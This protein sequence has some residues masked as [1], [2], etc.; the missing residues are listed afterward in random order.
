M[1]DILVRCPET[2]KPV[3]TGLDAE[4]VVLETL[5]GVALPVQCPHCGQ[6]H[7]WKPAE[8]WVWHGKSTRP[9]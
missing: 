4:T 5:P 3:Q 7:F 6:T 9:H 8:A 1:P 2:G